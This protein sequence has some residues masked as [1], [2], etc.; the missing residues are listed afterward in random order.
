MEAAVAEEDVA[1][2]QL[3]P[4]FFQPLEEFDAV[5]HL[6]SCLPDTLSPTFLT[7]QTSQTQVI[8]DAINSQLSMRVMRSYGAFVHG[9]AQVQQLESDMVHTAILCRSSRRHLGRVQSGMVEGS[10]RVLGKLRRKRVVVQLLRLARG[11]ARLRD[12]IARLGTLLHPPVAAQTLP[13]AASLLRQ[14]RD[15]LAS[16]RGVTLAQELAPRVGVFADSLIASLHQA[17]TKASTDFV[18]PAFGSAMA[19]AAGFLSAPDLAKAVQNSFVGAIKECTKEVL[20]LHVGK[21]GR[22]GAPRADANYKDLCIRLDKEYVD[23][24]LAHTFEALVRVMHSLHQMSVWVAEAEAGEHADEWALVNDRASAAS[25]APG[26]LLQVRVSLEQMRSTVW[27]LMQR[28]VAVFLGAAPMGLF[29]VEQHLDVVL[30]LQ[31]FMKLG[32]AFSDADSQGLRTALRDKSRSFL[33]QYHRERLDE[34]RMSLETES[35]QALPLQPGWSFSSLRELRSVTFPPRLQCHK[36]FHPPTRASAPT[37]T[38]LASSSLRYR[39]ACAFFG[40]LASTASPLVVRTMGELLSSTDDDDA[41]P[42]P[43]SAPPDGPPPVV[44]STALNVARSIGAYARIIRAIGVL[45]PEALRA[46]SGLFELYLYVL[47]SV[48]WSGPPLGSSAFDEI[49]HSMP[50]PLKAML[51]RIHTAMQSASAVSFDDSSTE[52]AAAV[53]RTASSIAFDRLRSPLEDKELMALKETVVGMESLRG[54]SELLTS[55]APA[56]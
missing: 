53:R 22:V 21:T 13:R 42:A 28:R 1:E 18:P 51:Q 24:C 17:L 49:G 46:L 20:L 52:L 5:H 3:A 11:L 43:T 39:E 19:C 31:C 26:W 16:L 41:N 8:L 40:A 38:R 56:V 48:F 6:L 36:L 7:S 37:T 35:W 2:L 10:L 12:G 14:C 30:G 27:E 45:A 23:S 44:C 55:Q 25:A 34:L 4:E 15:E 32:E 54:L 29:T 9:M 47:F 50:A 33:A